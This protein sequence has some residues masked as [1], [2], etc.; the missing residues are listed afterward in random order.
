MREKCVHFHFI[1]CT[2]KISTIRY[3]E[4][5]VFSTSINDVIEVDFYLRLEQLAFTN[6]SR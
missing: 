1:L 2:K 4:T 6:E 5:S 3:K